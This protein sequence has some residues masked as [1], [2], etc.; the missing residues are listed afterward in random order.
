MPL[1]FGTT[2]Y[3]SHSNWN[4]DTQNTNNLH[5]HK[6]LKSLVHAGCTFLDRKF[7]IMKTNPS[8]KKSQEW[9]FLR[10]DLLEGDMKDRFRNVDNLL[11]L[12]SGVHCMVLLTC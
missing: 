9:L 8:W 2:Y 5:K 1:D 6:M 11:C 12:K 3:C 4:N 7:K 10:V